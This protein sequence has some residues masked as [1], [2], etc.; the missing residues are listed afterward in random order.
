MFQFCFLEGFVVVDHNPVL[1]LITKSIGYSQCFGRAN[2]IAILQ[3]RNEVIERLLIFG[4]VIAD[5]T[6]EPRL[7]FFILQMLPVLRA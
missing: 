3:T 5:K 4:K 6:F 7:I 1:N 2:G